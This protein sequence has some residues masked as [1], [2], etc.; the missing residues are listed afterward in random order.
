MKTEINLK[1]SIKWWQDQEMNKSKVQKQ[2]TLRKER[3]EQNIQKQV[4]KPTQ[5]EH[6]TLDLNNS[7]Q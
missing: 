2:H 1:D 3:D 5:C 7:F 6:G 4:K